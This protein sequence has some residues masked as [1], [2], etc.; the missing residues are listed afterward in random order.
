VLH[1]I[2]ALGA[3]LTDYVTKMRRFNS[4]AWIVGIASLLMLS[5]GLYSPEFVGFQ[6]R[7]AVFAQEMLRHGPSVFPTV[8][9]EP[10]P[11]YPA[12]STLLIW[13][14]SKPFGA[15]T[16]FTAILPTALFSA[17]TLAVTYRLLRPVSPLWAFLA[18]CTTMTTVMFF[19]EARSISLDQMLATI[20][21]LAFYLLWR[22]DFAA[23][24]QPSRHVMPWIYVL[25][26]VGF[27]IR[28][29]MGV[30]VPAG[31]ICSYFCCLR[32]WRALL[33]FG[34]VALLLIVVCWGALMGLAYL[35]GG[36]SF[37]EDVTRMQVAQRLDRSLHSPVYY[38]FFNSIGNYAFCFLPAF[39]V[40]VWLAP[41]FFQQPRKTQD[42]L[43]LLL[44]AWAL[45]LLLG[46]SIPHAKKAR[47][48]LPAVPALAALAA[49]PIAF[50]H[51][52]WLRFLR[53][54]MQVCWWS[55]PWLGIAALIYLPSYAQKR[56]LTIDINVA[57]NM[58][59]LV[60]C[61]GGM[62]IVEWR[63]RQKPWRDAAIAAVAVLA[64]WIINAQIREP[65]DAQMRSGH[66]F[67]ATVEQL[68]QTQP[69]PLVLY[70][71]SRDAVA[72][73]YL[74][75]ADAE[76]KPVFMADPQQLTTQPLPVYLMAKSTELSSLQTAGIKLP[77]PVF[78]GRFYGDDYVVYFL[79]QVD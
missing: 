39:G 20:T 60:L 25:L 22:R 44:A 1:L 19:S 55:L 4:E 9:G 26:M 46:L 27:A 15:V 73:V 31:V 37:V 29:P 76:I 71:M 53:R 64:F 75:N 7:F 5:V 69:A 3:K 54:F 21:T 13:L 79:A 56:G 45:V 74:V 38:Y 47:Y 50:A 48:L 24:G 66:A 14:L 18:V 17:T 8:L 30:V 58:V 78:A 41:R 65:A 68:R 51:T 16:K 49:Y 6:T 63:G 42:R 52:R 67:V 35:D 11:D 40:I 61:A 34:S 36:R 12:T 43:L 28:G 62:C 10:Y 2:L 72:I 59:A 23:P 70:R 33:Q 77:A 32:R 57:P